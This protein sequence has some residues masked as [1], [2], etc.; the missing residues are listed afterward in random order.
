MLVL[1]WYLW[2]TAGKDMRSSHRKNTQGNYT[3]GVGLG[4]VCVKERVE[5]VG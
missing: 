1:G 4:W 2:R 3:T 5:E